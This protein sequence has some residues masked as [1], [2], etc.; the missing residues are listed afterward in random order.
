MIQT[1][2]DLGSPG[3]LH[4]PI[5]LGMEAQNEHVHVNVPVR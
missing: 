2:V 5:S 1:S 3:N 4:V